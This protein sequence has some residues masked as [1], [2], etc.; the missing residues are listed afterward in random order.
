MKD[1]RKLLFKCVENEIPAFVLCGTDKLAV[2]VLEAY[3]QLAKEENC[4]ELFINDLKLLIND[5]IQFQ[6]EEPEKIKL[7]D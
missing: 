6:K 3:C 4:S 5:Y 1:Q 2:R 7:P